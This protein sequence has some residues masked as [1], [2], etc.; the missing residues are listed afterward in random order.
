MEHHFFKAKEYTV[1]QSPQNEIPA[2]TVPQSRKEPHDEQVYDH[3]GF[4]LA[5]TS[6][7]NIYVFSEPYAEG[8]MPT[9]PEVGHTVG[10][11]G[12]VEILA[13]GETKHFS[14]TYCHIGITGKIKVDMEGIEKKSKPCRKD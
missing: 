13:E 14:Q 6:Q 2:C 5:V 9:S 11:V 10:N 4:S 3:S 7:R 8:Y 12:I 1:I